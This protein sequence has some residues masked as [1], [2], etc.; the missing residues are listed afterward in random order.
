MSNLIH[1]E[2]AHEEEKSRSSAQGDTLQRTF[3][4]Y[5][6]DKRRSVLKLTI[7]IEE[8][9]YDPYDQAVPEVG[10]DD[11]EDVMFS[12]DEK[13]M[14]QEE[15]LASPLHGGENYQDEIAGRT[16]SE[17]V[18]GPSTGKKPVPERPAK[19]CGTPS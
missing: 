4:N 16:Q 2:I 9:P 13:Q 12:P 19:A 1:D 3:S 7:E 5:S 11:I 6:Q 10:V 18:A 15:L 17:V 14:H 8:P